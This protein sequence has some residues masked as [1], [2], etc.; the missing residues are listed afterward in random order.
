MLHGLALRDRLRDVGLGDPYAFA[1]SFH[2]TTAKDIQPWFT[3]VRDED[4]HRF[5]EID[6]GIRGEEYRPAD[7]WWELDQA[8]RCAAA[9]DPD[10][11]R[12]FVRAALMIEPLDEALAC[13]GDVE[14]VRQLGADWRPRTRPGTRSG[15]TSRSG[16]RLNGREWLNLIKLEA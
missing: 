8:L 7:R 13:N 1:R 11:L 6:A 3:W 15:S 5:A 10:C 9:R 2:H 4:R 16:Q 14:R 12:V